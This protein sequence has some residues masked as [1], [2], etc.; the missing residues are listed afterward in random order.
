[1]PGTALFVPGGLRSCQARYCFCLEGVGATGV[2]LHLARDL[3][4]TGSKT[5]ACGVSDIIE[6]A[7]F[8]TAARQIASKLAP[9]ASG[10]NQKPRHLPSTAS[11]RRTCT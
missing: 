7:D 3:P 11:A 6:S 4:G 9:T 2:A 5:C 8:A 10:Q 1:M